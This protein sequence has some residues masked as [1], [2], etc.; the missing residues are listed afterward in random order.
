[1][2]ECIVTVEDDINRHA[3]SAKPGPD[4]SGQDLEILDNEHSHDLCPFGFARVVATFSLSMG[5]DDIGPTMT[6][7]RCQHGVNR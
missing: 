2:I 6:G 1:M 3:L 7:P 5:R 4:R